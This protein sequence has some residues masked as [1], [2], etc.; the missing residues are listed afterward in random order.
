MSHSVLVVGGGLSGLFCA[1]KLAPIPVTLLTSG[2]VGA[3]APGSGEA[4]DIAA[5]ILAA[6]DPE[7]LARN[8]IEAGAGL[9]D[10]AMVQGVAREA[11]ARLRDLLALGVPAE[12]GSDAIGALAAAAR[13]TPSIRIVE[14]LVAEALIEENDRFLGVRARGDA[15]FAPRATFLP[16]SAIVLAT[17]GIGPL[18]GPP[19]GAAEPGAFGIALAAGVG[20]VVGD[21]E[22]TEFRPDTTEPGAGTRTCHHLG[23]VR[24]DGSGRTN[25]PFLWAVGECAA[26]GTHGAGPASNALIE[27]LVLAARVADDLRA[28]PPDDAPARA[29]GDPPEATAER[30]LTRLD[31]EERLPALRAIMARQVGP[32]RDGTGLKEAV[33]AL[34]RLRAEADGL[35]MEHAASSALMIAAAALL[36]RES[37][38]VH[39]RSDHPEPDPKAARRR[40]MRLDEALTVAERLAA[41]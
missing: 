5:A 9:T 23:G 12:A 18:Y 28:L 20:A 41:A 19:A 14:G 34:A 35:V 15:G 38:G 21:V 32:V 6:R 7:A 16:A 27:A 17:G 3:G 36:R 31:V 24:V 22:F 40:S 2:P 33:A 13:R 30:P 1:L 29:V 26:T 11:G 10:R 25:V 37:R 39:R 4:R 8:A